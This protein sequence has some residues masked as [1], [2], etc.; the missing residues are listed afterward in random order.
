MTALLDS[1]VE[2]GVDRG[3]A[4]RALARVEA[5]RMLRSPV[6]I[7]AAVLFLT[8]WTYGWVSGSINRYPVLADDVVTAQ[9][10]A[11]LILANGALVTA[12]LAALRPYRHR[13]DVLFDVLVLPKAWRTGALLLA[14]LAPTGLALVLT[15]LRTGVLAA[16]PGAA[17]APAWADV[18]TGPAVVALFGTLGVLLAGVTRSAVVAPV[19]AL[20]VTSCAF[21][22]PVGAASGSRVRLLL[23]IISPEFPMPVPSDLAERPAARHLLYLVGVIAVL[24]VLALVRSGARRMWVAGAL[25]VI[26]AV[27]GAATQYRTDPSLREV[28]LT[29]TNTPNALQTCRTVGDVRYCAFDDFRPWIEDWDAVLRSVRRAVPTTVGPPLVVRQ[30]VL[31][32]GYP[33][34]GTVTSLEEEQERAEVVERANVDA[35]TPEAIP[36]G[37]EWGNDRSAAVFAGAVAYRLMTGRSWRDGL[38]VCGS[39]GALLIWL[40]GQASER[41]AAGLRELDETSWNSLVLGD[42]S[43]YAMIGVPDPDA[44]AGLALLDK[45]DAAQLVRQHWAELTAPSTDADR[46]AALVGVPAAEQP[47]AEERTQC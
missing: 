41:T 25:A 13:A 40:V 27:G 20:V 23:P 2:T 28:R 1:P 33:E 22:A 6:T 7:A 37:T 44:A 16:L 45:P 26:V 39:R 42:S 18:L 47:P 12:N 32:E 29:A 9:F 10:L 14:V 3:R 19:V 36:I 46:F 21:I 11:L 8:P 35:G 15:G 30:R 5:V 4:M 43:G 17:G 34:S 24:A 38:P 31:A